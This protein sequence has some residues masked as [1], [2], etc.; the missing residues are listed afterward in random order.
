[1]TEKYDKVSG[2]YS[3]L[4]YDQYERII[5]PELPRLYM[6]SHEITTSMYNF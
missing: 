1:M 4:N 6:A 3:M 5:R 2:E